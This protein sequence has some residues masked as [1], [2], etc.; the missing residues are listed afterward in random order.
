MRL[1][2]I[3]HHLNRG[4]VS[5][6]I[7]NHLR[8]LSVLSESIRPER[9]ALIFDGQADGW[10][11]DDIREATAFPID[12]LVIDRIGY[13]QSDSNC[14][15]KL[16]ADQ[17]ESSLI[18]SQ[19][20]PSDTVL[21]WHNHSLGKNASV[22]DAIA[23]LAQRGWKLLLQVH[24]FAEDNRPAN[25]LH[26]QNQLGGMEVANKLYPQASNIQYV[27]LTSR[28]ASIL[29]EANV[30]AS[31]LTTI[32]NPILSFDSLPSRNEVRSTVLNKLSIDDPATRLLVYPVRGIRR[33]N[34]GEMLLLST[35]SKELATPS[36][37]AITLAP[38]NPRELESFQRWKQL[39]VEL[40]LPCRF[41]TGGSY[42]VD[43]LDLLASSDAIL[44]TSI[45]EGFGMVFMEA[46]LIGKPLVGRDLPD[47]TTD[48]KQSGLNLNSLYPELAIPTELID[49]EAVFI[50]LIESYQALRDAYQ[51]KRESAESIRSKYEQLITDG[52]IDF[53]RLPSDHQQKVIELASCDSSVR[54]I[55][56]QSNKGLMEVWLASEER[57]QETI[58]Q[59]RESVLTKYSENSI[60]DRLH[61]TYSSLLTARSADKVAPADGNH[62]LNWFVT[63]N[64]I[65]PIRIES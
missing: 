26:L 34:V 57:D 1:A 25:Y 20:S 31:K 33:K 22:P 2:I 41:D 10:P 9:V 30:D 54:E 35:L 42:Q 58:A 15:P 50:S 59:N 32:P 12:S 63:P 11:N 38:K 6:V 60:G 5:Q 29:S 3:H 40:E 28:D 53:A 44:T 7:G 52:R 17:M 61:Q 65:I 4:G 23:I 45:A 47:I 14:E 48:F 49:I 37:F 55:I 46:W 24:D 36:S 16:L 39:A 19:Y 27:T 43:F 64:K 13:D 8:S 21:H 62:V 18:G 56:V 51:L